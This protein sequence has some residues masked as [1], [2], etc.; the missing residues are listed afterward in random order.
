MMKFS[1]RVS[2]G[3]ALFRL[4]A[5]VFKKWHWQL[6]AFPILAFLFGLLLLAVITVPFCA[7]LYPSGLSW[8]HPNSVLDSPAAREISRRLDKLSPS[9]ENPS[10]SSTKTK[11][12][13]WMTVL[14]V[15]AAIGVLF[16]T[17]TVVETF[18]SVAFVRMLIHLLRGQEC[19]VRE[20]LMFSFTRLKSIVEFSLLV[21]I[22]CVFI[23]GVRAL[24]GKIAGK[25]FS[26]PVAWLI[27]L[28]LTGLEIAWT[29]AMAICLPV[30]VNEGISCGHAIKRT[31]AILRQSAIENVVG[32]AG[33]SVISLLIFAATAIA[34]IAIIILGLALGHGV[35]GLIAGSGF[36]VLCVGL[37]ILIQSA[38]SQLYYTAAY[39]LCVE[40]AL[41]DPD[42]SEL[43]QY[44]WTIR[45]RPS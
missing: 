13:N 23:E 38:F 33:I 11:S 15:S 34:V 20:A 3:W 14:I 7:P 36:F 21:V 18:F 35:I 43:A 29:M 22:V 32:Y 17:L 45:A 12:V 6:L 31:A 24:V 26:A 40:G 8:G 28:P 27:G 44:V 5:R 37:L 39:I 30:M 16:F 25:Y 19:T 42:V 9:I 2:Q 10:S 1:E 4:S 41:P